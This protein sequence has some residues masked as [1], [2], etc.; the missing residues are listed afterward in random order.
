MIKFSKGF[1]HLISSY[2]QAEFTENEAKDL[3]EKILGPSFS[4]DYSFCSKGR[5]NIYNFFYNKEFVYKQYDPNY[6][7]F[8]YFLKKENHFVKI[9]AAHSGY[10]ITHAGILLLL[11]NADKFRITSEEEEC[12]RESEAEIITCLEL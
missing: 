9:A 3:L 11:A 7:E 12:I 6:G 4:L 8:K 2:S 5:S 1:E 10:F